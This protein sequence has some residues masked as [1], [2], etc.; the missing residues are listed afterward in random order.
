MRE[1]L[2]GDGHGVNEFHVESIAELL[3]PGGDLVKVDE[4]RAPVPLKDDHPAAAAL[5]LDHLEGLER[6]AK[7]ESLI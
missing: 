3:D 6:L 2:E 1:Y 7:L 4:L 5:L